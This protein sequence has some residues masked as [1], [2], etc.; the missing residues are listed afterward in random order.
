MKTFFGGSRVKLGDHPVA[1]SIRS[2]GISSR[3]F[4]SVYYPERSGILPSGTVIEKGVR[5]LDGH[6]GEDR[7]AVHSIEYPGSGTRSIG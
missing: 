6:R 3:P 5:P 4:M 7:K 2:L 1:E